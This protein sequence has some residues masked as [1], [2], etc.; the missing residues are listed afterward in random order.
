MAYF[1]PVTTFLSYENDGTGVRVAYLLGCVVTFDSQQGPGIHQNGVTELWVV[2][3][4][5]LRT[6]AD[7]NS[8]SWDAEQGGVVHAVHA[9]PSIVATIA[10]V[11]NSVE[12]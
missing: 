4:S 12:V 7:G 5:F 1:P 2:F 3:L 10:I 6:G 11:S 9:M 8:V